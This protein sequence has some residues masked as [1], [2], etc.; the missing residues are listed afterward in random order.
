MKSTLIIL[1]TFTFI[2]CKQKEVEQKTIIQSLQNIKNKTDIRDCKCYNELKEKTIKIFT[3]SDNNS[4]SICG[5]EENNEYFEFGIFDCKSKKLIS[6]Y[7][8]IQTCELKFEN[9]KLQIIELNKLPTN[10]KWEWNNVKVAEEIITIKNNSIIS[11]GVK[12]L[13]VE[14]KISEKTQTEFLNSLETE[15]YKKFDTEEVLA[16]LEILSIIGNERAKKKL[17]SI[18]ND[19]NYELDG[20]YMEQ[21]RSA[22]ASIK[23]REKKL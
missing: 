22:I 9:D 4:I 8:A 20:A 3:F 10:D 18:E 5:Y 17:L 23:W 21:Y 13:K 19:K 7:D 1:L 2:S 16:R 12:P 6:G 14:T 15:K 11:L